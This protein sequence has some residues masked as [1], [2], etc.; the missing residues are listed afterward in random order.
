MRLFNEKGNDGCNKQVHKQKNF[1]GQRRYDKGT[2]GST[3]THILYLIF[4]I[5]NMNIKSKAFYVSKNIDY[6]FQTYKFFN[7]FVFYL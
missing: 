5:I 4:E 6:A 1:L 7:I 2:R 3:Y